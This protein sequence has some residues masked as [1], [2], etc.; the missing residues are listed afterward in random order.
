MLLYSA[1][2]GVVLVGGAPYWILRMLGS[3]RYRA[4]LRQRLGGVPKGLAE[5]AK[6]REV[7]WLH[8]VSVGEVMAA[9]EVVRGL[10]EAR[11]GLVVAVSTTTATGQEVARRRMEG[12]PV[13]YLPLDFAVLVRRYLGVLRP[14]LMVL[15]ESEL[16]P[17]LLRECGRAG[18]PVA[19]VNARVSDRSFPR[20]MRLRRLW[21]PLL[22]RVSVFLAQGGETAERLRA[23]GVEAERVR[24]VGN[25]KYDVR[26]LAEGS[27]VERLRGRLREGTRVLVCGS[28]LEGEEEMLLRMWPGLAA[29]GAVMVLAP[30]HPERF[31]RVVEMVRGAGLRVWRASALADGL[32]AG[33]GPGER[34]SF[35]RV[36]RESFRAGDVVVLDTIGDLAEVYSLGS[37]A[38]VGGSLVS[39][40][41]HN[42][43]EPARFGVAV[44]IGSSFNNFREV[45]ERM[46]ATDGIWVVPEAEMPGAL[47]ELLVSEDAARELGERGRAVFAEQAGATG[48]TLEA[49]LE[50]MGSGSGRRS[51]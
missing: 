22:G 2:L 35:G 21:R 10:V 9:A 49:L 29:A 13:F 47:G 19:V 4:G 39:A 3:G 32:E 31:G 8:A 38:F 18:V 45:V 27:M 15:M 48:R 25:L 24:V 30:R 28:T 33:Q 50:V 17:N 46:Q 51:G 14:R 34:E 12:M 5:A 36:D 11:P 42:P 6:G 26:A 16:W 23:M 37:V 43:L 41:G 7:V 44:V 40:G 20:Y 1:L